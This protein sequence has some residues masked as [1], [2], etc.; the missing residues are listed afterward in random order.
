MSEVKITD[1]TA[2]ASAADSD[3]LVIVDVANDTT[4]KITKANLVSN[5]AAKG[6]NGGGSS[7]ANIADSGD[8]VVVTGPLKVGDMV[9]SADG[10]AAGTT[11]LRSDS[12]GNI[13]IGVPDTSTIFSQLEV[14][15]TGITTTHLETT[16]V[17]IFNNLPTSDPA[18]AGQLWNDAGA[19][20]ISA[21]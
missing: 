16:Q 8:G 2:A 10:T 15:G 6:S 14:R 11:V 18:V 3:V 5:L 21:G 4:K 12:D 1:L 17:V 9:F 13:G 20:K 19:L 7:L